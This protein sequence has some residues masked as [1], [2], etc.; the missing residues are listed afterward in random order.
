MANTTIMLFLLL[1]LLIAL[2]LAERR[3]ARCD[4]RWPGLVLPGI[5]FVWT[6]SIPLNLTAAPTAEAIVA[7]LLVWLQANIPTVVLLAVYGMERQKLAHRRQ[8]EKMNIQD[9]D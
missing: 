5:G 3:L 7:M 4:A 9:L 6:L 8:L 1:A 2:Y